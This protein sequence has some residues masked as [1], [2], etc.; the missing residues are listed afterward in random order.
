MI[1]NG[2]L[3]EDEFVYFLDGKKAKDISPNLRTMMERLFGIVDPEKKISCKKT[4]DMIKPD[5]IIKH[6]KIEKAVSIKYGRTTVLH[7][8]QIKPFIL[9]LRE[10]GISNR[11]QQ[12]I[13]LFQ[14]GDGTNDGTGAK[15]YCADDVRAMM[16]DRIKE[17]NEELNS[18]KEFVEK[19]MDRIAFDGVDPEA[20]KADAIYYG[21]V[22]DGVVVTRGQ[23]H[24]HLAK[25]NWDYYTS[26]HIGPIN[27]TPC[28]RYVNKP[29]TNEKKRHSIQCYWPKFASDMIYIS[30]RYNYYS[31]PYKRKST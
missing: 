27:L 20:R 23:M 24:K 4:Q 6:M 29:V 1:N 15:R 17:A 16:K 10:N 18:N 9:F 3:K 14:Y 11:T 25:N 8:E 26:I 5:I 13:L 22:E 7:E 21:D 30:N 28:A 19:F 2:Y 31:S 12:T